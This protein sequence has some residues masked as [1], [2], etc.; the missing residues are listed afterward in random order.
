MKALHAGSAMDRVERVLV[1]RLG[2]LGDTVVALPCFHLIA[3]HFTHAERRVLTNF[4]VAGK[5]A[6]LMSVLEGCGLVH[7][8]FHYP[9]GLRD[10]RALLALRAEIRH[11]RPEVL[12]YLAAPRGRLALWRD[13]AFFR[14]CGIGRTVGAPLSRDLATH[15]ALPEGLWEAEASRLAR[16]L[17][18]LGDAAVDEPGSWDLR[19]GP[20]EE[21]AAERALAGWPGKGEFLA[22]GIG[23]KFPVNDWGEANW[24]AAI[25]ELGR[26]HGALG[27]VT[28]GAVEEAERSQAVAAAWPG[29]RLDLCGRLAP[30]ESAALLRRARLFMG[31]DSGP[32]H[33]AAAVGVRVVAVFSAR[34][35]PGVWFPHGHGHRVL[36]PVTACAECK[37]ADCRRYGKSCIVS[38]TPAEV[39]RAVDEA[40]SA[41]DPLG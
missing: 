1:Y 35:P 12:V 36:Y 3:R 8:A 34:N 29:P 31:H 40:L 32:M 6:P 18:P 10:P 24:Q 11:W 4:P 28:L 26:R 38:I 30:R 19:L 21:T 20:A 39:A 13:L 15:K 25:A 7:G 5:A 16:C 17:A 9:V 41:L 37:R 33:L 27:L 14:L 2:S 23:T 22:L